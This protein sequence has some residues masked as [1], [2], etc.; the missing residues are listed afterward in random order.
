MR[1]SSLTLMIK[2]VFNPIQKVVCNIINAVVVQQK[3]IQ[4]NN[5]NNE[6]NQNK[7]KTTMHS[8]EFVSIPI[9]D[10][11]HV[12]NHQNQM[13]ISIIIDHVQH[14]CM[15]RNS[16]VFFNEICLAIQLVLNKARFM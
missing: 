16:P 5:N 1:I 8:N 11:T 9:S 10:V 14:M 2:H 4:T 12:H 15:C 7:T 3:K 6:K 13:H